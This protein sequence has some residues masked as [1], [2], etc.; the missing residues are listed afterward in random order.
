MQRTTLLIHLLYVLTCLEIMKV[1]FLYVDAESGI[2]IAEKL[3]HSAVQVSQEVFHFPVG[4]SMVIQR[5]VIL[6]HS[7]RWTGLITFP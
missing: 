3:L 4:I 1:M 6:S 7:C 5:Q 2:W